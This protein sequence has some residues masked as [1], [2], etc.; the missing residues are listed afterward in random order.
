MT[1]IAAKIYIIC[2]TI[3]N[4]AKYRMPLKISIVRK[5][6]LREK[7]GAVVREDRYSAD[8][9]YLLMRF[10]FAIYQGKCQK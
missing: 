9:A 10:A 7:T 3:E 5:L 8:Y 6:R 4:Q 1:F 2:H